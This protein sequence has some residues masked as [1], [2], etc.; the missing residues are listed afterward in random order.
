[1]SSTLH[2]QFST[3]SAQNKF[4]W[5]AL[6][7]LVPLA[8]H[9]LRWQSVVVSRAACLTRPCNSPSPCRQP[10]EVEVTGTHDSAERAYSMIME[11]IN[12]DGS[13]Q[14]QQLISKVRQA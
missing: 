3:A 5:L 2:Q 10:R 9:G 1:M 8:L 13:A 4:S 11:I 14:P 12:T 7:L 6:P